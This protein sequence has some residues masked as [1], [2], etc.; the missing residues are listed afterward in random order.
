MYVYIYIMYI[1]IHIHLSLSLFLSCVHLGQTSRRLKLG[2]VWPR[3]KVMIPKRYG[4][5]SCISRTLQVLTQRDHDLNQ[6]TFGG[7]WNLGPA[8]AAC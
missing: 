6:G 4:G 7:C 1:Y 8:W 3:L 5:R 2:G